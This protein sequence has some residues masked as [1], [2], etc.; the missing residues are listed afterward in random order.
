MD[1]LEWL[2][3]HSPSARPSRE[4]TRRHR[5]QLRGAIAAEGADGTRPRRPR[6]ERRSRHRVLLTTTVIVAICALGAG[7]IALMSGG[8]DDTNHVGAPA[9][10]DSTASTAPT[11]ACTDLPPQTLAIPEGFGN[12]VAGP[13]KDAATAP[14]AGQQVTSWSS[15]T[16]TIEQRWPADADVAKKYGPVVPGTGPADGSSTAVSEGVSHVD[17]NGVA[18]RIAVFDFSGLP[19]GCSILQ[20]TVSG[21]DQ[22][23]VD[24]VTEEFTAAPFVRR[25]PLVTT[26]AA[27]AFAPSVIPCRGPEVRAAGMKA[28]PEFVATVGGKVEGPAFGQPAD[29]LAGFLPGMK[30]LPQSGYQ[31]LQLDDSSVVFA[32]PGPLGGTV[33]TV[34]VAPTPTGWMVDE[35]Q[36]SGC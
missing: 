1:E 24:R 16:T 10:S 7:A 3:E 35:W 31:Q 15:G 29:A 34:H 33:T 17:A 25:E 20:V 11:P 21:R 9:P 26:T 30:T 23:D 22:S 5:T 27:A 32:K 4:V 13:A 2:K 36:A 14:S 18:R 19:A 28:Q 6:R 12:P 8:G